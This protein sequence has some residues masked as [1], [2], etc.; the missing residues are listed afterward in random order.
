MVVKP[1]MLKGREIWWMNQEWL[2]LRCGANG[3]SC[4]RHF[5]RYHPVTVISNGILIGKQIKIIDSVN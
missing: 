5:L 4:M 2:E 3:L 1:G